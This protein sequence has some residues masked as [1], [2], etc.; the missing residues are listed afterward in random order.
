MGI[1]SERCI[2]R[3]RGGWH[4]RSN[5]GGFQATLY[6]TL[7]C[8]SDGR[9]GTISLSP[10]DQSH[11]VRVTPTP[12][13]GQSIARPKASSIHPSPPSHIPRLGNACGKLAKSNG[14]KEFHSSR[15]RTGR[16]TPSQRVLGRVSQTT[17]SISQTRALVSH[18][19]KSSDLSLHHCYPMQNTSTR[20]NQTS[21][22]D[23]VAIELGMV[24]F[25]GK[26]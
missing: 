26:C 8:A 16:T 19:L 24:A 13:M 14:T 21:G 18:R 10:Y 7:A 11:R 23:V 4:G 5:Q 1:P 22:M 2:P 3:G 15:K 12:S 20:I 6:H 25:L 9:N 17:L